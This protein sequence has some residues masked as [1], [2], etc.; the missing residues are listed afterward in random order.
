MI[1]QADSPELLERKGRFG[2]KTWAECNNQEEDR[3]V[4]DKTAEFLEQAHLVCTGF[5][6]SESLNTDFSILCER[7]RGGLCLAM[8][9]GRIACVKPSL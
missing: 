9:I 7:G 5:G 4:D 1:A 6:A 3:E 2:R 8:K